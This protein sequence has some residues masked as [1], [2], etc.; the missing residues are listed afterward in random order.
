MIRPIMT[1]Q[2][3][4]KQQSA[5]ANAG[6]IEIARDLEDTLEAHKATCAGMAANMIGERKRIIAVVDEDGSVLIMF[7][8]ELVHWSDPYTAHE[9]CLS[10]P[11]TREATRYKRILV[12][13]EDSLMRSCQRKFEGHVAQAIQHE[14]D[15]C[16]GVLI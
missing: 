12:S 14:I 7:N 6:D 10:L 15:H 16:N 9:G 11:G 13:Y 1:R 2:F 8:P 4:L 3:F 5:E